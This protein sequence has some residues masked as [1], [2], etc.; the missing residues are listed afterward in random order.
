MIK[1][2]FLFT[3]VTFIVGVSLYGG[4]PYYASLKGDT[5]RMGNAQIERCM[6][7]N[8]GNPV[9]I[10]LLNKINGQKLSTK[11]KNPDFSLVEDTPKEARF[12][13]KIIPSNG[14]HPNYLEATIASSYGSLCVERKYRIYADCPAIACDTYLKG[15]LGD[16]N[17]GA[18]Q[19]G[20]DRKNIESAGDMNTGV[21]TPTLDRLQLDGNHWKVRT[22]E[23]FDYTDWNDNLVVE[24]EWFTYRR[25]TFKGNLLF[26]NDELDGNGFFFLK[27]AP[28]SSTQLHYTGADFVA[29]FS[30]F[31]VVGLG[32]VAS[33]IRENDWTRLYGC[34]TGIYAGGEREA[35]PALRK[36]QKQ[37]RLQ[38]AKQDEMIMLNTWGD[39]SQD[40]KIDEK[41]CLAELD[42][43]A[44]MGITVFQLDDGWQNGKS[45]NSKTAGGSFNDIWKKRDYWIPN[46][47]KFP[48]GLKPIVEKGKKLGIRIGLWFN[49]SIQDDFADWQKDADV[50]ISLYHQY[51]IECFKI[52]GLQIPTKQAEKNLRKLF[53]RVLEQTQHKVIF[54]LDATAGRRGGYHFM[55]EYGN[56]FLENRYTDWGNY[57]PYRTLRNLWQLSRYVPAEK[58]QVEFL[59]NW[60]NHDKYPPTDVFAPQHYSFEYLFAVTLAAQPLAWMEASNLPE[61]AFNQTALSEAYKKI[62]LPFHQGTILPIGEEPSG[63]SWTGFQSI[64]NAH[65][66]FIIVYRED[67]NRS[68]AQLKTWLSK[69]QKV[70]FVPVYGSGASFTAE[71]NSGS[72]VTFSL[73]D[74]NDFT[75][76]Q[77]TITE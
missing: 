66:G 21:K 26:A 31:M 69:G 40:S 45:P 34:V 75:L 24:R 63:R 25:N 16:Y 10:Y 20:A 64:S 60:R 43:A 37:L 35:L 50:I 67:N 51:G 17:H 54:N 5:L 68:S 42:K 33:D 15:H 7:W 47:V 28:C 39:R 30:D 71:V 70:F 56:I 19:S 12:S 9:T 14:I 22:V 36:Y 59:N 8:S 55:N 11:A 27:E 3:F 1:K 41:F 2:T 23:F 52:D 32:A 74:K 76:Y 4:E 44:R 53:D 58:L 72:E 73:P 61:S 46:P 6:R 65:S 77:Y 49:P 48:H 57:Y 29:D 62:Q 38:T 18:T 13:A